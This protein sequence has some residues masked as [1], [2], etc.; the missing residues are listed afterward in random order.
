MG[1]VFGNS[2]FFGFVCEMEGN[3]LRDLV[4]FVSLFFLFRS[5]FSWVVLVVGL[6]GYFRYYF[7]IVGVLGLFWE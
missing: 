6:G 2:Y 1:G 7:V 3:C 4:I 5:S